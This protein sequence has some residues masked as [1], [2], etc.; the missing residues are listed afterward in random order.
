MQHTIAFYNIENLFDT[1]DDPQTNDDDF[2]PNSDKRWTEKRYH[3]KL[4]KL[5]SVICKIGNNTKAP[6]VII[7]L[8]EVENDLVLKELLKSDKM[9]KHDY[10]FVHY[11]SM[12]ERGIDVALLYD[13]ERFNV[14]S[15]EIFNVHLEADGEIDY[16]RDIL[17]V[18]GE[19]DGEMIHVIVNHWPS[20]REGEKV[21]APKRMIA[22]EKVLYIIDKLKVEFLDPKIIVM[23]DFND[24]PSN[25]SLKFL[26]DKGLLFNPMETLLS[27]DKGSLSY[28]SEWNLFDQILC[29]INFME[30]KLGALKYKSVDVYD[31]KF[32]TQYEGK[33]EGQP[34]RTYVGKNYK[35]GFSDHFP[36]YIKVKKNV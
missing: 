3:K 1:V 30:T 25:D 7:G 11:N 15:S 29:S 32:L 14:M 26:V 5:G 36:V 2:L 13:N 18:S 28:N 21:S 23:G 20:R 34:F 6:P 9:K 27:I 10:S 31:E 8:A 17:L 24:N 35:G 4:D 19:L 16:T 33:Y 22:A 12:D